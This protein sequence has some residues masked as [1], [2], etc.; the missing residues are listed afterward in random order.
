MRGADVVL[1]ARRLS[2]EPRWCAAAWLREGRSSR[3]VGGLQ[4]GAMREA[5]DEALERSC[6]FVGYAPRSTRA[7]TSRSPSATAASTAARPAATCSGSAGG[8]F[9][10]RGSDAEITLFKSVGAALEDLAAA[11]AVM[12]G[13]EA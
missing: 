3:P 8:R 2:K 1:P 11:M 13:L 12:R 6:V 10:G 5:D 7:A 4:P 9:A